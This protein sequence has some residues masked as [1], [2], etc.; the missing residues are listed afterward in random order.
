[1]IENKND[2]VLTQKMNYKK[3]YCIMFN[4]ATDAVRSI[5]AGEYELARRRL[6]AAQ[7]QAEEIYISD[8]EERRQ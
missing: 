7:K 8:A 1:M 5:D 6:A 4:A 2:A 3:M